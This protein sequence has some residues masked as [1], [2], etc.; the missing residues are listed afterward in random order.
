MGAF[1]DALDSITKKFRETIE[2]FILIVF[3]AFVLGEFYVIWASKVN[4]NYIW[5]PIGLFIIYLI[6]MW[7]SK[8]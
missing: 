2:Y 8:K 1:R 5:Y 6:Y 7:V 4:S 3:L